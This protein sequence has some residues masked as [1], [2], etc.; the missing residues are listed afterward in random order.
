MKKVERNFS[1]PIESEKVTAKLTAL[2]EVFRI[3][4][5]FDNIVP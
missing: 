1:Q 3:L 5:D 4:H 2:Q